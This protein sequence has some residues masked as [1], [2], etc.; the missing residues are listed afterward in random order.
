MAVEADALEL[1]PDMTK[2]VCSAS[3]PRLCEIRVRRRS[4]CGSWACT[5]GTS[6]LLRSRLDDTLL[7]P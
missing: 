3:Q 4:A 7:L 1:S 2:G 6:V 5:P